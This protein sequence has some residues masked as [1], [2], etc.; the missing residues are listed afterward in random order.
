VVEQIDQPVFFIHGEDDPVI[1][2]DETIELYS[3]SDNP[4][5]RI[6]IVPSAEHVNIYRK[7][8]EE[9]VERVSRFFRRH[10]N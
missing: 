7:M 2:V 3:I 8:P 6:W 1:P 9:Y 10:I 5:D 4:Q